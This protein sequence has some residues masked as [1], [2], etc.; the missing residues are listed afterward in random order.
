MP[1][2]LAPSQWGAAMGVYIVGFVAYNATLAFY[3][4]IFPRLALNTQHLRELQEKLDRGEISTN[5]YEQSESLEKSKISS[6]SIVS[7][8][9]CLPS[10]GGYMPWQGASSCGTCILLLLDLAILIPL[11]GN[12]KVNN[13][14]ILL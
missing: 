12:A 5:E 2:K 8:F 14:V 13:Y 3:A 4:A 6:V 7:T 10:V 9:A 11:Q 1:R